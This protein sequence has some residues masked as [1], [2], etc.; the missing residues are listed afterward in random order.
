MT[1][2][3]TRMAQKTLGIAPIVKPVKLPRFSL[4]P[5]IQSN[6]HEGFEMTGEEKPAEMDH[7]E[8]VDRPSMVSDEPGESKLIKEEN[9]VPSKPSD[10]KVRQ[11]TKQKQSETNDKM[12]DNKFQSGQKK[13]PKAI[14]VQIYENLKTAPSEKQF[15]RPTQKPVNPLAPVYKL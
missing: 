4:E 5:T 13:D 7:R 15:M 14:Q 2:F 12:D 6:E 1:D 9:L 11:E 10:L 8:E 3:F